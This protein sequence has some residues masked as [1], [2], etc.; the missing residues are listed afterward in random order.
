MNEN[1]LPAWARERLQH[2]ID[3]HLGRRLAIAELASMVGY[4]ESYFYRAFRATFGSSPHAYVLTR[5]LERA[6]Q[7]MLATDDALSDIAIRCGL[8]DQAHFTRLFRRAFDM[9]PGDWRR[10][11]RSRVALETV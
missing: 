10:R 2:F 7:L 8:A 4:S 1:S 9:P 5:R 6:C 11:E 3:A